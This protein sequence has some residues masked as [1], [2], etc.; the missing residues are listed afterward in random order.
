MRKRLR[1]RCW[2]ATLEGSRICIQDLL[3][4]DGG[5]IAKYVRPVLP[6]H[7]LGRRHLLFTLWRDLPCV[8]QKARTCGLEDFKER[9]CIYQSASALMM[10]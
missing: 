2:E 7:A 3:Q 8:G 4:L 6:A 5:R 9:K 10:S 1:I